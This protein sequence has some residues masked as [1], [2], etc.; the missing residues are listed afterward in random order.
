MSFPPI[1]IVTSVVAA[2]TDWICVERRSD[3]FAPEHATNA[4]DV[5][6]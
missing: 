3:V 2:V 6:G 1:V 5:P 4:S